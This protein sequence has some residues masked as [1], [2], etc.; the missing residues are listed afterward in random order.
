MS[1]LDAILVAD[2]SGRYVAVNPAAETLI[3]QS[4]R[5]I[6]GKSIADFSLVTF[7]FKSAWTHF[8]EEGHA[9][10]EFR[11]R[12]PDGEVRD[13]EFSAVAHVGP[14]RHVSIL[15]DISEAKRRERAL[16]EASIRKDHFLALLSHEIRNPLGAVTNAIQLLQVLGPPE[17]RQKEARDIIQRQVAHLTRLAD[18]LLEASRASRGKI[19]LDKIDIAL[20]EPVSLGVE[21]IR[22]A[23]EKRK[24]KVIVTAPPIPIR[25]S[26]DVNRLAQVVSNLV[27]NASKFSAEGARIWVT[28]ERGG[29]AIIRVRDEGFGIAPDHLPEVFESFSQ[30]NAHHPSEQGLGLGLSLVRDLVALH[31]GTVVASSA[32]MPWKRI[33]R[34]SADRSASARLR[35]AGPASGH[36]SSRSAFNNSQTEERRKSTFR[37]DLPPPDRPAGKGR[38]RPDAP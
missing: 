1:A 22:A 35:G 14:D 8:L 31:G 21:A 30:F 37:R 13:V 38:R 25:V 9:R 19:T 32:G 24:Q 5:Q 18:D 29:E 16:R 23:I 7:D 20:D 17:P 12:R 34:E 27:H 2:S 36:G 26:G 10:G 11:L 4:A 6:T 15:R 3:G 28:L 33:R